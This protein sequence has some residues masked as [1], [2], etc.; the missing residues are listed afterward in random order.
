M[1]LR[2]V[3]YLTQAQ[4]TTLQSTGT[5]VVDGVTYTYSENDLYLVP[6]EDIVVDNT[7]TSGSDNPVSSGGV[8]TALQGKQNTLTFDAEPTKDSANPVTSNGVLDGINTASPFYRIPLPILQYS[9]GTYS[10]DEA[11]DPVYTYLPK[12]QLAQF[13]NAVTTLSL[14]YDYGYGATYLGMW[15][16]NGKVVGDN[17][18][19]GNYHLMRR[20]SNGDGTF[21][22]WV[23]VLSTDEVLTAVDADDNP[24]YGQRM[25][26]AYQ[27][28]IYDS[29]MEM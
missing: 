8:Y 26:G 9:G 10:I 3:M 18:M 21:D 6:S 4:Y 17:G 27:Y 19:Y 11:R 2:N 22:S 28:G 13:S 20:Y 16:S 23:E 12:N 15:I 5:L 14:E 7:P 24:Y 1:S 29:S 25:F